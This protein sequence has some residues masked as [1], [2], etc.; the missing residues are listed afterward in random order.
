MKP[1]LLRL[2]K[3][4][5]CFTVD[6]LKKTGLNGSVYDFSVDYDTIDISN[7]GDIHKYLMEKHNIVSMSGFINQTLMVLVM[8]LLAFGGSLGTKYVYLNNQPYTTRSILADFNTDKL[9]HYPFMDSL[10]KCVGSCNTVGDPFGG[11]CAP[12]KIE[13]KI[14]KCSI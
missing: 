7:T 3:P 12:N 8:L 1:Y 2:G 4:S 11:I 10:Y 5:K 14:L 9:C 6:N 13:D